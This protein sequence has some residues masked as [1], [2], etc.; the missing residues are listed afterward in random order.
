MTRKVHR[1]DFIYKNHISYDEHEIL[2]NVLVEH[3]I[4]VIFF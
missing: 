4:D 2:Q 1:Y 3:F